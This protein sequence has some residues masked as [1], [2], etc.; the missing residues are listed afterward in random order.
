VVE[1]GVLP[2]QQQ[3]VAELQVV[4]DL[5]VG[6]NVLV[7]HLGTPHHADLPAPLA[8]PQ[9]QLGLLAVGEVALVEEPHVL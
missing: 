5:G 8:G 7:A 2:H 6:P 9:G 3:G 4:D 1:P